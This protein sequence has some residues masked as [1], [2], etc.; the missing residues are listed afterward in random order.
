[1]I[2]RPDYEPVPEIISVPVEPVAERDRVFHL[3]GDTGQGHIVVIW[4][5]KSCPEPMIRGEYCFSPDAGKM[6]IGVGATR[7]PIS[8]ESLV[9]YWEQYHR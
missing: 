8:T 3:F 5:D 6:Y 9:E 7:M 1:M 4:E 2:N